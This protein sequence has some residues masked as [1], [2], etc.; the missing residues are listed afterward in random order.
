MILMNCIFKSCNLIVL[1]VA[2]DLLF[3]STIRPTS[4]A[5]DPVMV[6]LVPEATTYTLDG[7]DIMQGVEYTITLVATNPNGN[8]NESNSV[9]FELGPGK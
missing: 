1:P 6:R 9:M 2:F 5:V 8:S 4:R 7:A 3:P